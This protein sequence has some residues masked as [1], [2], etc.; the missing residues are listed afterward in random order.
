MCLTGLP[1]GFCCL[2]RFSIRWLLILRGGASDRWSLLTPL[3]EVLLRGIDDLPDGLNIL[4]VC[5]VLCH[6]L[7]SVRV[8]P[9][10]ELC[11][12]GLCFLQQHLKVANVLLYAAP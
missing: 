5:V 6:E 8:Q 11:T 9:M 1:G 3:L 7:R 2:L 10:L 12:V 4:E